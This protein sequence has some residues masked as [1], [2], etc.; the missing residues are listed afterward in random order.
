MKLYHRI[1]GGNIDVPVNR[2]EAMAKKGWLLKKRA[3]VKF[4]KPEPLKTESNDNPA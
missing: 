2:V 4:K 1:T 3:K